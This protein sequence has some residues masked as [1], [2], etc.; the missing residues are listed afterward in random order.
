[1]YVPF[2]CSKQILIPVSCLF[3]FFFIYFAPPPPTATFSL[4]SVHSIYHMTD[5]LCFTIINVLFPFQFPVIHLTMKQSCD[6]RSHVTVLVL[7]SLFSL[8]AFLFD[9]FLRIPKPITVATAW[10][11][12]SGDNSCACHLYYASLEFFHALIDGWFR[13]TTSKATNCTIFPAWEDDTCFVMC[14][15]VERRQRMPLHQTIIWPFNQRITYVRW[16]WEVMLLNC[17]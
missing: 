17:P 3:L 2:A 10:G 8:T 7:I 16:W 12:Q 14:Q 13:D 11:L 4:A 6:T 9:F 1:M 15:V 5:L